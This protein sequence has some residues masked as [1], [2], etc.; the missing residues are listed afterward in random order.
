MVSYLEHGSD[1]FAYGMADATFS[2]PSND[3]VISCMIKI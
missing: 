1:L 2:F 3:C